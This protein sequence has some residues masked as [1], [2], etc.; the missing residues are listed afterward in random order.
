M[1]L[2]TKTFFYDWVVYTYD[3]K[4]FKTHLEQIK[5]SI[6][7]Q[8]YEISGYTHGII[9]K[10]TYLF[11]NRKHTEFI[12]LHP[13]LV[14]Q[15]EQFLTLEE[16]YRKDV[17]FLSQFAINVRLS[18]NNDTQLESYIPNFQ[19]SDYKYKQDTFKN[20]VKTDKMLSILN[21]YKGFSLL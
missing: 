6:Q 7:N 21:F 5:A 3:I 15:C 12:Q 13:S 20:P 17:S 18:S 8:Q 9:Y 14:E 16:R 2:D 4:S 10:D 19:H 1:I 11:D